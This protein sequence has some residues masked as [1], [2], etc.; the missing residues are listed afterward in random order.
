MTIQLS[1][2][3][4]MLVEICAGQSA[5]QGVVI[6]ARTKLPLSRATIKIRSQ[7]IEVSA[8]GNGRFQLQAEKTSDSLEVSHVG[9]KTFKKPINEVTSTLTIALEDYSIQLKTLTIN[10]K[11]LNIRQVDNSLRRI[12]GNLYA[13]ETEMTNGPYNLFLQSLRDDAQDELLSVCD[14]D[15]SSYDKP[16]REY[17]QNYSAVPSHTINKKDTLYKDFMDYPA[18]NISHEAA[19][20]FCQWFSE[21]YNS[22]PGK[23]KF[24][25]VRFR[26]PTLNEWQIAAL[27]YPKFQ[28]W[29]LSEN[30]VE[31]V[32][33]N[34]TISETRKGRKATIPVNDEILYP[35]WMAYNYRKKVQNS[36]NCFL[37]NFKILK[38]DKPC[39]AQI[40]GYDGWT[41]MSLTGA[42]FPNG[43]GL[44]DVVGNVAEMIDEKG[45]ACGGSWNDIP[46][47]STIAS[48]KS[49]A[50]PSDTVGFRLFMEVLEE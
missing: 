21:Q 22:S 4:I 8:D 36:K 7:N 19:V 31:V 2:A 5:I 27:G 14:F 30:M 6:D 42:Y 24:K 10:S 47:E 34:D 1:V 38:T 41:K 28:S 25:K 35:W 15:L 45:K 49:Y 37:G 46:S 11:T 44:S 50:G 17:Y 48:V 32:I 29:V 3:L 33:P 12:K 43:M 16:S 18:V 39:P 20:I 13:Y 40:P 9:Y 23:K 26:L